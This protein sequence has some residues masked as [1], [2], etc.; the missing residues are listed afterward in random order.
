MKSSDTT[1]ADESKE[2]AERSESDK[3]TNQSASDERQ[4]SDAENEAVTAPAVIQ[5]PD[6]ISGSFIYTYSWLNLWVYTC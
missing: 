4:A 3:S 1:S 5:P 6:L 2:E